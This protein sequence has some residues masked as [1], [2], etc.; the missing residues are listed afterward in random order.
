MARVH[1]RLRPLDPLGTGLHD[2]LEATLGEGALA[3]LAQRSSLDLSLDLGP[4][5]RARVNVYRSSR[6]LTA[7]IRLLREEPPALATLGLPLPID[8]LAH[9][10]SGLVLVTGPTGCGKSTT[11]AALASLA[12][13]ERSIVLL[14]LE[15]P[16]EY[17]LAAGEASLVRQRQIGADVRDYPSGLRDALREDPDVLLIGEMRDAES[18]Q[19]ALTAAETGHLVLAS[20]HARS[21]AAAVERVIDTYPAERQQ[22]IR[23]MLADSLR[24]VVAQR[25]LPTARGDRAL[26]AEVLRVTTSVAAAIRE[27]RLGAIRSAMQSGRDSGM[28]ILEKVL[29]EMVRARLISPEVARA[30]ATDAA[31]LGQYL[32]ERTRD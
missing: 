25:L 19:L 32:G 12:L 23:V 15:D 21:A 6:G 28:V 8:D 7:A 24:A 27:G 29:A 14:S 9:L 17:R 13:R 5:Q 16:I 26:A 18:I 1:G 20:L 3:A 31:M 11:L 10:S 2:L 30:N 22:Q 4:G